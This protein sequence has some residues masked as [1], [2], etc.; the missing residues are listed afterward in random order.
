MASNDIES[1]SEFG[2]S[3]IDIPDVPE[4]EFGVNMS[5][6]LQPLIPP[7]QDIPIEQLHMVSFVFLS[8][9]VLI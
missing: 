5:A 9:S 7:P 1:S 8:V 6:L 4:A 2:E 3:D